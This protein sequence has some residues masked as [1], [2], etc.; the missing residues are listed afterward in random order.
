MRRVGCA[1]LITTSY[2]LTLPAANAARPLTTDDAGVLDSA[3]CEIDTFVERSRVR[4]E[5]SYLGGSLQAGCG[6]GLN[7]QL[8]MVG[9]GFDG[10]PATTHLGLT[11][12]TG[13]IPLTESGPSLTVGYAFEWARHSG[14]P[15]RLDTAS[16]IAIASVPFEKNWFAHV[17]AGWQRTQTPRENAL[18]WGVAIE[19]EAVADSRVDLMAETYGAGESSPWLALG[20]RFHAIDQRLS[21]NGSIAIKSGAE[22]ETRATIGARLAF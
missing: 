4:G 1:A 14:Q 10:E 3:Q 12:K 13:L 7:T 6:I 20:A 22:R 17:N 16:L 5:P 15:F 2:A 19:R 11:G 18:F 9:A 8:S 21:I